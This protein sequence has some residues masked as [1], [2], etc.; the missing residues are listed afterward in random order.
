MAAAVAQV[1]ILDERYTWV[2]GNKY[3]VV[4]TV[5]VSAGPATYTG[6]GIAMNLMVPLVK[7]TRTPIMMIFMGQSG[8]EYRY[9]PGP[10]ASS[11]LLKIMVQDATATNPLA[12]LANGSAI[13]AA[14][15][16][17]TITFQAIFNGQL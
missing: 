15:S 10:D 6:G 13:P 16:G 5:A 9:V 17:D 1:S 8:L 3:F 2:A 12:E 11:G 4:G 7:A 14:V